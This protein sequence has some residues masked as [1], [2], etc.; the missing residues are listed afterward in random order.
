MKVWLVIFLFVASG[1]SAVA[2]RES[3]TKKD[4]PDTIIKERL[5]EIRQ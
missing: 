1:C 4:F 5:K 2:V 3:S